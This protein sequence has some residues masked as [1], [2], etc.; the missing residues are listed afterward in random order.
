MSKKRKKG[1]SKSRK[2]KIKQKKSIKK[3]L[4]IK[5]AIIAFIIAIALGIFFYNKHKA[6]KNLVSSES[7]APLFDPQAL[8]KFY[9]ENLLNKE[10]SFSI[11]MGNIEAKPLEKESMP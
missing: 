11:M 10:K 7:S 6:K 8:E 4:W 2:P 9:K 1:P 3:Q 5:I